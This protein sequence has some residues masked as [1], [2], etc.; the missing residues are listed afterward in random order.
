VRSRVAAARAAAAQRWQPI[1]VRTN[2]EV[3]GPALRQRF[4]P[5]DATMAVLRAA[6]DRGKLNLRGADRTL[7]IAWSIADLAGVNS[8][9][10]DHVATALSFRQGGVS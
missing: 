3:P 5:G 8:P 6:V 1:G 2:A 7:R 4:R 10:P 9:T